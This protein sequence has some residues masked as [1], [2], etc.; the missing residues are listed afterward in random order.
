MLLPL[1]ESD[2]FEVMMACVE[3]R[4]AQQAVQWA[5]GCT[6]TVVCA[7]PGY[8]EAYPKGLPISGLAEAAELPGVT[9]FH[10]GTKLSSVGGSDGSGGVDSERVET[11]GGRVLAVTGV[12]PDLRA[13]VASAYSGVAKISFD[14]MHRRTDIARR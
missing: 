2:L 7:A 10:A 9:V 1:L 13:A 11:S 8:P 5:P 14:G 12:G 3:G 6:C 4:L